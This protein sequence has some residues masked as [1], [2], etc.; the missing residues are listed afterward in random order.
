MNKDL[1][2]VKNISNKKIKKI[3]IQYLVKQLNTNSK[4]NQQLLNEQL[5]CI[6]ELFKIYNIIVNKYGLYV[7][8]TIDKIVL[9]IARK[10][11]RCNK[12]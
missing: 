5:D 9:K 6:Q 2:E 7:S 11:R 8:D 4:N 12:Y 1:Q 3:N 10:W